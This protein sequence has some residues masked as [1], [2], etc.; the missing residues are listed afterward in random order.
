[1]I[2]PFLELR[3]LFHRQILHEP[4]Q[5]L[6]FAYFLNSGLISLMIETREGKTV[7]VGM[8]ARE[9]ILGIETVV[10]LRKSPLREV[11]QIEGEGYRIEVPALQSCLLSTPKLRAMLDR[12]AVIQC[13]QVAQTAAC[14]RLH[15]VE[16]RFA[17]SLLTLQA[18]SNSDSLTITHDFLAAILG[19]DRPSV[20]LAAKKCQRKQIIEYK[21]GTVKIVNRRKLEKLACECYA[22]IQQ[23]VGDSESA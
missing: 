10:G 19:T 4:N 3:Q 13:L 8:V 21:R 9:G 7:E 18:R 12:Y 5:K 22:I 2:L 20:S 1:M 14:N 16:Q 11:V 17:R 15:N 23:L 6:Q